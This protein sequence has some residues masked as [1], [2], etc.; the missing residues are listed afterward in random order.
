MAILH[1]SGLKYLGASRGVRIITDAGNIMFYPTSNKYVY[2]NKSYT[3]DA[4]DVIEFIR[5][6][7]RNNINDQYMDIK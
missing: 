7:S 1:N 4:T 5:R 3:G 6:I 2:K